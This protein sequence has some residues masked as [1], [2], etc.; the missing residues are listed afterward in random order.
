MA[1]DRINLAGWGH[2]SGLGA[3]SLAGL[4][5]SASGFHGLTK[6]VAK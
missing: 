5:E 6:G 4:A 2:G 1:G 3:G